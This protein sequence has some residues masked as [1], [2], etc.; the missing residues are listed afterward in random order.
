MILFTN[1]DTLHVPQLQLTTVSIP[2][3]AFIMASGPYNIT[4]RQKFPNTETL[5]LVEVM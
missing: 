1:F 4:M 5:T 2:H 3:S